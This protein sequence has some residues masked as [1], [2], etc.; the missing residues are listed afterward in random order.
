MA[1]DAK[2]RDLIIELAKKG[3]DVPGVGDAIAALALEKMPAVVPGAKVTKLPGDSKSLFSRIKGAVDAIRG[4]TPTTYFGPGQPLHPAAPA[5]D[6]GAIGRRFDFWPNQNIQFLP[7][8]EANAGVPFEILRSLAENYD[9]LRLVIETRKD[10]VASF[11]W[12][13]LPV[14]P[15]A[16]KTQH[17]GEIDEATRFLEQPAPHLDW[18]DWVRMIAEDLFV[19]DGVA[20]YPTMNRRGGLF[21]LQPIDV[22]LIKMLVDETGCTPP[23]PSPA[24]Q[25]ILKGLPAVNYTTDELIYWMRN[26][27]SWKMYGMSPVEQIIVTVNIALRRQQY[28]LEYYTS[29]SVPDA[30]IGVTADWTPG[31]IKD[32]QEQWDSQMAG[33]T[34]TRR[35]LTFLPKWE[36]QILP[37]D[38]T[39]ALADSFDEWLARVI[40]FAFSIPPTAFVKMMNRASG[41]KMAETAKE[42]GLLPLM[43]WLEL[44]INRVLQ[45]RM[46][47][48]NIRFSW[49]LAE[50]LDPQVAAQI[51]QGDVKAGIIGYDEAREEMGRAPIGVGNV[52]IT[53]TGVMPL[54]DSVDDAINKIQN[55]PPP[56]PQL[57]PF[58]GGEHPAP[59][60]GKDKTPPAGGGGKEVGK[61]LGTVLSKATK[62]KVPRKKLTVDAMLKSSEATVRQ[63]VE[64]ALSRASSSVV[65]QAIAAYRKFTKISEDDIVE[66]ILKQIDTDVVGIAVVDSVTPSLKRAFRDAGVAAVAEAGIDLPAD[67]LSHLDQAAADYAQ[68]R[69]AE[70]VGKRMNASGKIVNNPDAQWSIGSATRDELR[71]AIEDAVKQGLSTTDLSN[72]I[73]GAGAFSKYRAEMIARTELSFAHVAGNLAGYAQAGD[74]VVGKRWVAAPDCCDEC[75]E[76]DG[77]EVGIDE[78]FP[79]GEDGPPL[80]PN[81]RCDVVAVMAQ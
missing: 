45:T 16:S 62:R 21:S 75:Q 49:K 76:L 68:A 8:T 52:V 69:G 77:T 47:C 22:A 81:C 32:F 7:K 70:L 40:C 55:P 64:R 28:Q 35:R 1:I 29:G 54:K 18:P 39:V 58:A 6:Q 2:R 56:P 43:K 53:A 37:K 66:A 12:E 71:T 72:A 42:E 25:Q 13:I 60:D 30:L 50:E 41:E 63:G 44:K 24:Y 38:T 73:R 3:A 17:K 48:P 19:C 51:R 15:K 20:L 65:K 9:L 26:P 14:D 33:V 61:Y 67:A 74:L 78:S 23:P 46:Q 10:Q 5:P 80:H 4:I 34:A 59:T 36:Q 11:E 57:A 79:G 31:Q 27:R